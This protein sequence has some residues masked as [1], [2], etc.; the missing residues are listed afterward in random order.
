MKCKFLQLSEVVTQINAFL[1]TEPEFS[2][3]PSFE[4]FYTIPNPDYSRES[5]GYRDLL[6]LYIGE[7]YAS[8]KL[9]DVEHLIEYDL[10]F[11]PWRGGFDFHIWIDGSRLLFDN[12]TD[13]TINSPYL[14]TEEEYFQNSTIQ[15]M[16]GVDLETIISTYKL[17]ERMYTYFGIVPVPFE[18][19]EYGK[20]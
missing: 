7:R 1:D 8:V 17:Q 16:R 10:R 5:G 3:T 19:Y 4:V 14:S 11:L 15:D 13:Q 9:H 6:D 20:T 12:K 2:K 18:G